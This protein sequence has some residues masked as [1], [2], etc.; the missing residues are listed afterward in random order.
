MMGTPSG[1]VML[2]RLLQSRKALSPILVTG[3]PPMVFGITSSPVAAALQ[4]V[5]DDRESKRYVYQTEHFEITSEFPLKDS[6][7]DNL[8]ILR[9]NCRSYVLSMPLTLH[10]PQAESEG[11]RNE[12][13][14]Y[15]TDGSSQANG[16]VPTTRGIVIGVRGSNRSLLL[17][18]DSDQRDLS[19]N[20]VHK[21]SLCRRTVFHE[22]TRQMDAPQRNVVEPEIWWLEGFANVIG[23]P[24]FTKSGFDDKRLLKEIIPFIATQW[25]NLGPT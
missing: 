7:R 3:L 5:S 21:L 15:Q 6:L 10:L 25:S 9:E 16:G 17:V 24:P 4:S 14:L 13:F 12:I 2:I 8:G 18:E 23:L 1:I 20:A 22:M 11:R 19:G